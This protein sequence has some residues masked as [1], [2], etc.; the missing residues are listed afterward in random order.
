MIR[1][2]CE[3]R[4]THKAWPRRRS[5]AIETGESG[6]NAR[7][8]RFQKVGSMVT[9]TEDTGCV[10]LTECRLI[11]RDCAAFK[12]RGRGRDGCCCRVV[13]RGCRCGWDWIPVGLDA[14]ARH[15]HYM[16]PPFGNAR[17]SAIGNNNVELTLTR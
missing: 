2:Q 13:K 5:M 4:I 17:A 15:N 11:R 12:W 10:D 8:S 6:V 3:S 1:I 9:E 7:R 16:Y 14:G